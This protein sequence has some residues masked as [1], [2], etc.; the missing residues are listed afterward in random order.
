M[1]LANTPSLIA[2]VKRELPPTAP[3]PAVVQ[4][5]GCRWWPFAYLER[6]RARYGDRFTVYPVDMPPLVF[7]SDPEDIKTLI[8]APATVLHPGEGGTVIAPLVGESSFML[9]EGDEHTCGRSA[10]MPAFHRRVVQEHAAMAEEIVERDIAS[11]PLDTVFPLHPRLRSMALTVIL[12]VVFGGDDPELQTLH[13]QLFDSL[14]VAGSFVLQEPWL[15]HLPGW[16][17]TWKQFVKRSAVADESIFALVARRRAQGPGRGDLLDMLLQAR[18]PNGSPMSDHQLRDNLMSMIVA[19]HETTAA[20]LSWAFQLL[21]HN[22]PVQDRLIEEIDNGT[23]EQYLTA[24]VHETLR[25]RPTFLFI[26]PRAVVEPIEIGGFTYRPPAHLMGCTYL[27]HHDPKLYPDPQAFRPERFLDESQQPHTWLPWGVGPKSCVGRHFAVQEVQMVLRQ[28][29]S[30][31]LVEP[32]SSR[33]EHPR[34]R[35]AVLVPHAGSRVIL[36]R[37][38]HPR[39]TAPQNHS[40][41]KPDGEHIFV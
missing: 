40:A 22:R 1:S 8:A 9:C 32:A 10:I 17:T 5:L 19:G 39:G 36:R 7:L 33:V 26:I 24:T 4:T 37:R 38:S 31:R 13:G 16:H 34:W 35:S 15:R 29:L 23:E 14:S 6:C 41:A 30:D 28:V 11:W 12:R 27:M 20:E 21:A 25:H 2:R 3:L 18:N